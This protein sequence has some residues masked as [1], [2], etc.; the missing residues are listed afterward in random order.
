MAAGEALTLAELD[1]ALAAIGGF[2]PAPLMAVGVSGGP[3]SLALVILADRWAR[4]RGGVAWALII[5]H[6]LRPESAAE[7]QRAAG[8]LAARGIP[9]AVLVWRQDKPATGI[10]AAARAARYRLLAE[11]CTGRGCLHLLTA[12]HRADQAETYLIRRRA[13]SAADGLAGMS[14]VREMPNVRLVRPLLTVPKARLVAFLR[15]EGQDYLQDPSN[16]NPAFERSRVRMD[17]EREGVEVTIAKMRRHA[18]SRIARERELAALLARSVTLHPAGFAVIDPAVI[19]AAGELGEQALGRVVM[20]LGGLAYPVRHERLRRLREGLAE[21]P[22]RA[23]TLGGCH[24]VPWRSRLLA[25]R[26]AARAA[27]PAT[28]APGRSLLWDR[29]FRA[30]LPSAAERPL[31]VGALG[32]DGVA[33]LGSA[34]GGDDN[35]LPRLVYPVL[36]ALWDEAGLAAVPHLGWRRATAA[37]AALLAFRPLVSLF[38][39]GFTV[40]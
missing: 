25:L 19:A 1:A 35:P 27:P 12:H 9:H 30:T 37:C 10:Q 16:R 17:S 13:K 26:E 8:W 11:W 14:A 38:G 34:S 36:P 22:D 20:V 39:A 2:E 3:D 5:D 28:L 21:A 40:V 31:Q 32:V 33:A 6:R 4:Q 18:R 24:F 29:R 15:T 23:R 7:A